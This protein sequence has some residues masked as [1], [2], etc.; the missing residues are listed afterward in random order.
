MGLCM[1]SG[2][3]VEESAATAMVLLPTGELREYPPPATAE[4]ALEDF[5]SGE[6]GWF[7]CDADAMGFEGPVPAVDGAKELRPGQIYFVLPADARKNGLRRED[8]A[9]L[10]VRA[11]AALVKK[12]SS[13]GGSGG[14]RRRAGSVAPLVFAPP[15]AEKEVDAYKTIP[16]LAPKRR[17]P[18]SRAMSAGRMQPRFAPD[19][20]AIP[21]CD[22]SE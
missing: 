2:A 20:S 17:P 19:L 5:A 3:A 1:S 7:L 9:E 18:V 16:A 21:E 6:K 10:A 15:A 14:R 4:R 11:S 8:I 22:T 12:A 13:V